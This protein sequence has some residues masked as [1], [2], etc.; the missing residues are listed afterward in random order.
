M[1]DLSIFRP[2]L[3]RAALPLCGVRPSVRILLGN[4][5]APSQKRDSTCLNRYESSY[6]TLK[7]ALE[8]TYTGDST[9]VDEDGKEEI[10]MRVVV[11]GGGEEEG[12]FLKNL[13]EKGAGK[14]VDG[15]YAL[16][17]PRQERARA[18]AFCRR[19]ESGVSGISPCVCPCVPFPSPLPESCETKR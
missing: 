19:V 7:E 10:L 2:T 11:V 9:A 5:L 17:D 15:L 13:S 18:E 3:A 14:L 8:E 1:L 12:D 16:W 4:P 6:P